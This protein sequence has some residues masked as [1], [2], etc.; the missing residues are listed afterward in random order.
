MKLLTIE[1]VC[2]LTT[3]KR[4][5]IYD[6]HREGTFPPGLKLGRSRRWPESDVVE[7]INGRRSWG[8]KRRTVF[9][10]AN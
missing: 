5:F 6:R 10:T 2:E 7:W 9:A 8:G 3:M 1:Q 4:A